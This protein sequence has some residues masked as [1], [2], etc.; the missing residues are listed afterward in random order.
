MFV[1]F[2][3]DHRAAFFIPVENLLFQLIFDEFAL[4][5]DDQYFFQPLDEG[6]NALRLQRPCHANLVQAQADIA[7][8][9]FGDS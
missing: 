1:I 5:L 2:T 7:G 6:L 4:F 8:D 9:R 3:D